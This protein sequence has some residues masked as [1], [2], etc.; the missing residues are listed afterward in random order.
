MTIAVV[1]VLGFALVIFASRDN[2]ATADDSPPQANI[3]HWHAAYG[4]YACDA[5]L[6]PIE[7]QDDP[8]GIHSHADGV[9]HIHP[10]VGAAAG[11][12]ATL[13]VFAD[14]VG[15]E[16][17]NDEITVPGVAT[18][19]NGQDCNGEPAS[20]KAAVWADENAE[21]PV[22]VTEDFGDIHFTNDRML[23][24]LA[25]V[26]DGTDIPKPESQ[27]QL[28]Q[29]TDVPQAPGTAALE[30]VG[31]YRHP[32]DR[33]SGDHRSALGDR[34]RH[35]RFVRAVVLVGG[36]GTR[37]RP[38]T[39]TKPKQMLPV[40]HRPM[41]DW[42]V[43]H[44]APF[45]IDE[46][47]LSLGY[48]PDAFIEAFPDSTCAGVRL[49]YAV[50]PEPLDTAGAVGFAARDAGIDET[51]LVVNGDVFTDLDVEL[52]GRLPSRTRRRRHHPPHAGRRSLD[53]RCRADRRRRPRDRVHREAAAR[54]SAD[55]P[56]QCG[57]LRARAVG[58]RPHRR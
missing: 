42:V 27:G 13:Q 6:T 14:A 44:L 36:F 3:D 11:K 57:H 41:I 23:I 31:G 38:L 49:R 56:H 22:I 24:T 30:F 47:I 48:K 29:L 19:K 33:R 37:L 55:E 53:V 32:G 39:L 35:H 52:A 58:A 8:E 18:F 50:E 12:N 9:I 1:L 51:F 25:F 17:S 45:G 40:V 43:G 34:C 46:A 21:T 20:W 26:P 4:I 54:R 28:D 10:W 16:L 5:F 15:L 7:V 2:E